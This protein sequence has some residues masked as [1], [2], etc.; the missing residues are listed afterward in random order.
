MLYHSNSN[1]SQ[2]NILG[3]LL[4]IAAGTGHATSLRLF[5]FVGISE[6]LFL[7]IVLYLFYRSPFF[8]LKKFNFSEFIIRSY[9]LLS[10]LFVLPLVS[11]IIL[12]LSPKPEMSDTIYI[13]S[14]ILGILLMF[15][16]AESMK[17]NLINFQLAALIFLITFVLIN[18]FTYLFEISVWEKQSRYSGLANNPNQ[19]V[20]YI[21]SLMLLL[22]IFRRKY[23]YLSFPFLIYVGIETRSD[24]FIV[25][26]VIFFLLIF[27]SIFNFKKTSI[28]I[29]LIMILPILITTVFLFANLYLEELITY[30]YSSDN[31]DLVRLDLM[32][33]ALLVTL[34]S[35]LVGWGAGSFSGL[36][37]PFEGSE[38]HNT[39]LDLSMQFGIIVPTIIY[40]IIF[41]AF[42]KALKQR[43][44]LLAAIIT[45]FVICSLFHFFA[46][47]FVFWLI[48]GI[49]FRY[50]YP[51]SGSSDVPTNHKP[52]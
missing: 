37:S 41:A 22:I 24:S 28:F 9:L 19:L 45:S 20:I 35:P 50:L 2:S 13:F 12:I 18:A 42:F 14:F 34:Y 30:L 29:R 46:R 38:A 52:I 51:S 39:F 1:K 4:G 44:H 15:L 47:H 5:D 11:I 40:C 26:I 3:F 10:F 17:S 43:K 7:F 23:F 48:I 16:V 33:N 21:I 32:Y 27:F 31:K 8:F 25:S 49:L 6:I 36:R